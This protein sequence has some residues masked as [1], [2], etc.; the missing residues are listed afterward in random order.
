V[1]EEFMTGEE[2]SIFAL[3]DGENYVALP[4]AQDHKRIFDNDEGK[5]TGG[6]GSYAPAPLFT[7]ELQKQ[8]QQKIIEPTLLA[9]KSENSTFSGCLYCG[10]MITEEGPKVVEFNCRFGDPEAQVVLPIIKG[11]FLKLL[12]SVAEGKIKPKYYQYDGASAVC[13]VAASKGYPDKYDKGLEIRGLDNTEEDIIVF[14]AGTK[15]VNEKI[16]TSGGRVLGVT[17][18]NEVTDIKACKIRAYEAIS[19]IQFDGM[20][21]RNDISDKAS[22]YL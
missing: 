17:A 14:H 19:N 12:Y 8:V 2:V 11:D 22:K 5:N 10:L 7:E 16:V 15:K 13:V 21:Y 9:M 3:T 6:M 1:I 20:Q 4:P 18:V